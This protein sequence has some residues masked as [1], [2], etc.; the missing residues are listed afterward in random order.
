MRKPLLNCLRLAAPQANIVGMTAKK[1]KAEP[2]ISKSSTRNINRTGSPVDEFPGVGS[3]VRAEHFQLILCPPRDFEIAY[4]IPKYL[5][6]SPYS[7]STV[8]LSVSEGATYRRIW[9][10]GDALMVP[11]SMTFRMRLT[12]PTETLCLEI[13]PEYADQA[14]ERVARGRP[15]SPAFVDEYKDPGFAALQREVRRCI[16][17]DPIKEPAYLEQLVEGMLSRLAC[18]MVG[19]STAVPAKEMLKSYVVRQLLNHI[20]THLAGK[21]SVKELADMAGLSRS[22]FTRAFQ[23]AMGEPPQEFIIGR[24]LCRAREILADDHMTIAEVATATGFSS[25]AHLATAFKKRLG[26][27]PSDYRIAFGAENEHQ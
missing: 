1:P 27:T 13:D 9:G 23:A 21:L 7:Q 25:Q 2:K 26:V 19:L 3:C 18:H 20:E 8:E 12:K 16:L 17:G 10:A 24:R 4:R 22:H 6:F 5:I 15:W 11:P 14:I